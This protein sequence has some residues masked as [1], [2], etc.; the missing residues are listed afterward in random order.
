[1]EKID[2]DK[3]IKLIQNVKVNFSKVIIGQKN[4]LEKILIALFTGGHVL[5]EGVPGLGKTK[6]IK[7]ISEISG[8]D[9]SRIQFTPDLLP[10]DILGTQ[11]YNQ[12][13]GEFSIKKRSFIFKYD[14][15]R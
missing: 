7:T 8:L 4:I 9:F 12:K 14:F 15:G 13:S 10:A 2:F 1:M 5:L 11:I 3:S 6:S